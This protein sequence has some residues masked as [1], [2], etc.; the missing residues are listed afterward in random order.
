MIEKILIANRGEIAIRVIKACNSLGLK[1]VAVYS[2]EDVNSKHVKMASESYH[3]GAAAPSQSYLNMDNIVEAALKSGADAIHP[4]YGFLSENADFAD[5]CEKKKLNFIGPSGKSMR[6]C[7]D[8]MLCKAA[9]TKAK[10]PT[11]PGSPGIVEEVEKALDIANAIGYPVLLKSV[12]GGGGRGIR[13]VHNESEL[14]QA[15]ELASGE[16]K[17]AFGKSALFVEKFLP[18]IRHIEFQ[19]ARDK[20]GNAVHIFERECS[21]QRRHQKL[22]EMSPSP[23]VDQKTRDEIGQLAVNA[24]IAVDYLNA[25]TAEFLRLDDG[26]FYFI[27]INA[28]LQVEH[29]VTELVSGLDLVKLQIDIANGKEIPFKQKDLKVNGCAIE[30]RINAED[31]FMDFAPSTGR[32]YDVNIPS[33]PGVRVDTYLY[34]G[35]TVSPYYD[36]LMAKLIAWGQ[37][38]E[39]ARQRM[40]LALSDFYIEGVETAIPLYRTILDTKEFIT[41]DMSTDFLD[42]FKVLDRLRDNIK[43]EA[44]QK[45]DV[46]LAATLIHSE[47]LKNRV[48]EQ[49]QQSLRWKAQLDRN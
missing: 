3:I 9:M 24:A 22:I 16:S 5:L 37:N 36:S 12:F 19:L 30:C 46:A 44:S 42:R 26:T 39:E 33:G 48:R 4:G 27:E 45:S 40:Q 17:A 20:H 28:R 38:F 1:S 43:K 15:F 31:T 7:G 13:L 25:G 18:K 10:V 21:I 2:D 35:C 14:R 32:I 49:K 11:V 23:V 8:K 41:G 34:P 6:L 47:F 29:P